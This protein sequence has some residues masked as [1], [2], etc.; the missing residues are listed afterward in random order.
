MA[1]INDS[2]FMY[3]NSYDNAV[4][5][6]TYENTVAYGDNAQKISLYGLCLK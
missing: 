3:F 5:S 1:V 4:Y 6:G 2:I